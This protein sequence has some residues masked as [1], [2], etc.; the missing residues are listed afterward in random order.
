[1]EIFDRIL[2]YSAVECNEINWPL[3]TWR[4]KK[5]GHLLPSASVNQHAGSK[6]TDKNIE[7]R[8]ERSEQNTPVNHI[9]WFQAQ[10]LRFGHGLRKKAQPKINKHKTTSNKKTCT[11][12]GVWMARQTNR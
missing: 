9:I 11:P 2:M 4:K 8:F 3:M 10:L 5:C 6:S 1:M 7:I 12:F